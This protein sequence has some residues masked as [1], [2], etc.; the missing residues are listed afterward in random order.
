[1]GSGTRHEA[2]DEDEISTGCPC[3]VERWVPEEEVV[4]LG[5][6]EKI[7]ALWKNPPDKCSN[8]LSRFLRRGA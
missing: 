2:I 4:I 6:S 5:E 7:H 8:A 3:K 1:M